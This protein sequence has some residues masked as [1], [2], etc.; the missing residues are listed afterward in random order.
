MQIV[1]ASCFPFKSGREKK[2]FFCSK[3]CGFLVS[4]GI[5]L[6]SSQL[7][8][9]LI[10]N[11]V[12]SG[13]FLFQKRNQIGPGHE[14]EESWAPPHRSPMP[15]ECMETWSLP[16]LQPK[17]R[18]QSISPGPGGNMLTYWL[19]SH[20]SGKQMSALSARD[21]TPCLASLEKLFQ[22]HCSIHLASVLLT[23]K[24]PSKVWE[25][26]PGMNS[27]SLP[28]HSDSYLYKCFLAETVN[29]NQ[30][31]TGVHNNREAMWVAIKRSSK[32]SQKYTTFVISQGQ[33]P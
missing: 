11:Q 15:W 9:Y 5:F 29:T 24:A 28:S 22:G 1:N 31:L 2:N 14:Q 25:R 19:S 27:T 17:T 13:S 21:N 23:Q 6:T 20:R 18:R 8:T 4:L 30:W 32:E 16:G 33:A 3:I 26:S 7:V 10:S 12:P